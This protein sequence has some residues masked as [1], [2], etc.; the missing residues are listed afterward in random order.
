MRIKF[1]NEYC[2]TNNKNGYD[3]KYFIIFQTMW[4]FNNIYKF[5]KLGKIVL[6][7]IL[8]LFFNVNLIKYAVNPTNYSGEFVT[9]SNSLKIDSIGVGRFELY[10][11]VNYI[12]ELNVLKENKT[13]VLSGRF[14]ELI[15]LLNYSMDGNRYLHTANCD[16]CSRHSYDVGKNMFVESKFWNIHELDE[17]IQKTNEAY[18]ITEEYCLAPNSKSFIVIDDG[19]ALILRDSDFYYEK[20]TLKF[21]DKVQRF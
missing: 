4:F 14:A 9:E 13:L 10:P 7:V 3:L 19:C 8:I 11:L 18:F 15:Q 6:F 1:Q 20:T 2:E 17:A 21:V 16:V 12:N 5:G